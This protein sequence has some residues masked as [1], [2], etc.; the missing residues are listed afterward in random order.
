[1]SDIK[2][3]LFPDEWGIGTSLSYIPINNIIMVPDIDP[4]FINALYQQYRLEENTIK[5]NDVEPP[6]IIINYHD[7]KWY[8][9]IEYYDPKTIN[10]NPLYTHSFNVSEE[11]IIK[12]LFN[13][14]S[15]NIRL[16]DVYSQTLEY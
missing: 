9:N 1:M 6:Q 3:N 7:N 15:N 8:V 2:N 4:Q 12:L 13:L 14:I 5:N 10:I 16:Y 11:T